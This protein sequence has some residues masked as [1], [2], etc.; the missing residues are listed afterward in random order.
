MTVQQKRIVVASTGPI[1]ERG[2]V[3]GPLLNPYLEKTDIIARMI[4]GGKAVYEVDKD[5]TELKLTLHNYNTENFGKS[6]TKPE[7]VKPPVVE[8]KPEPTVDPE[9][10]EPADV[11]EADLSI[12]SKQKNKKNR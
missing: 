6:V 1:A 8:A 3:Y 2:G 9:D 11:V 12:G 7:E 10:E 5:G 4:M